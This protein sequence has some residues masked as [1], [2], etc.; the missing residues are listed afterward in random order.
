MKLL[1]KKQ[2]METGD[3]VLFSY[4]DTKSL[5]EFNNLNIKQT[6]SDSD[7]LEQS[8][9]DEIWFQYEDKVW[10]S[11]TDNLIEAEKILKNWWD[12]RIDFDC[13]S[14]NWLF[15]EDAMF[16]VYD[17]EDIKRLINKLQGILIRNKEKWLY[18]D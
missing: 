18:K 12:I 5:M 1:N 11:G 9:L 16:I 4:F 13:Y 15:D 14:R 8:L 7:Y 3:D 6:F 10:T 17:K 2:F